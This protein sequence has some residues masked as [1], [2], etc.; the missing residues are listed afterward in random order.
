MVR[1]STATKRSA[2]LELAL[3]DPWT[4]RTL[5]VNSIPIGRLGPTGPAS[6]KFGKAFPTPGMDLETPRKARATGPSGFRRGF[7]GLLSSRLGQ[8]FSPCS[9]ADFSR[10]EDDASRDYYK[11]GLKIIQEA[12]ERGQE[13]TDLQ[14]DLALATADLATPISPGQNPGGRGSLPSPGSNS[15]LP[16]RENG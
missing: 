4:Q 12:A 3:G 11:T 8:G 2:A 13:K 7:R 15:S 14:N 1:R 9:H 10:K 6:V 16:G 5:T